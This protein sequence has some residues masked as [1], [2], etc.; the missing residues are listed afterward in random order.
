MAD[1]LQL[2]G[3]TLLALERFA[4]A[5]DTFEE[6]LR[7]RSLRGRPHARALIGLAQSAA[8]DQDPARAIAY[9][10]RVYTVHRA[11]NDLTA[12]AYFES[13]L[14]FEQLQQPAAAHRTLA[15]MLSLSELAS[16][17]YYE[18]ARTHQLLLAPHADAPTQEP[19]EGT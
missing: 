8:A 17:P 13:S 3:Q 2:T 9:Y 5:D 10:Q 4:E 19:P 12:Q 1:A 18:K 11:Q 14:L 15:E 6:I 16:S 7:L